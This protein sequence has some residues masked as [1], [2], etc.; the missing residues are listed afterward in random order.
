[1]GPCVLVCFSATL[2]HLGLVGCS[3]A[4]LPVL[5]FVLGGNTKEP[6]SNLCLKHPASRNLGVFWAEVGIKPQNMISMYSYTDH[7]AVS[8]QKS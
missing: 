8:F 3:S 7:S 1:M 4:I 6:C 5:D 2:L